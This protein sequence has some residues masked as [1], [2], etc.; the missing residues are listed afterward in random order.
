MRRAVGFVFCAVATLVQVVVLLVMLCVL[1]C[2]TSVRL[3]MYPVQLLTASVCVFDRFAGALV[4]KLPTAHPFGKWGVVAFMSGALVTASAATRPHACGTCLL[5]IAVAMACS[6]YDCVQKRAR[7]AKDAFD[8]DWTITATAV[9]LQRVTGTAEGRHAD[10]TAPA[11][12]MEVQAEMGVREAAQP[13]E[14]HD[15]PYVAT[16]PSGVDLRVSD[17]QRHDGTVV[18]YVPSRT[19]DP[20][21][22]E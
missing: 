16:T 8:A 11:E 3:A 21:T 22:S 14:R 5:V 7:G 12:K 20:E 18:D 10:R 6:V 17:L 13:C 15:D 2:L 19:V 9:T 1:F 4:H